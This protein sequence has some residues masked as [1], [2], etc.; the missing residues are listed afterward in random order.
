[1]LST[2]P[3]FSHFVHLW[4]PLSVW[5]APYTYQCSFPKCLLLMRNRYM[6][7]ESND[8]TLAGVCLHI[9]LVKPSQDPGSFLS[10]FLKHYHHDILYRW[11]LLNYLLLL[12]LQIP[13]KDGSPVPKTVPGME[14]YCTHTDWMNTWV[15]MTSL[16]IVRIDMCFYIKHHNC[17]HFFYLGTLK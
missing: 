13:H 4:A 1:M 2:N 16:R 11:H 14:R 5:T 6:V 12:E 9:T 8:L 10:S 15:C 7:K 17:Q 3:V